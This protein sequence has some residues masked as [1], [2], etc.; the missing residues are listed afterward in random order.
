[1]RQFGQRLAQARTARRLSS[2]AFASQLG[3]SRNTLRAAERGSPVVTLSTY[4]RILTAL[5]LE[6]DLALVACDAKSP[7]IISQRKKLLEAQ[8]AAGTRDARSLVAIPAKLAKE[9]RV[10]FPKNPF[11]KVRSW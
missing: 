5:D 8:V 7:D 10:T 9:S 4:M 2:S 1:M 3:M 6:L 11:G